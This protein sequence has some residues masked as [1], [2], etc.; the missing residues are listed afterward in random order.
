MTDGRR[1][2]SVAGS[3]DQDPGPGR[4]R[5]LV[6]RLPIAFLLVSTLVLRVPVSLR[7]QEEAALV[8]LTLE[9]AVAEARSGN[10]A[11]RTAEARAAMARA[12]ARAATGRLL[13]RLRGTAGFTRSVDPVFAFGTKL[14]QERF[15]EE[16][17]A[18][19]A[20]N[21]PEPITDWTAEAGVRWRAVD[22]ERW[23]GRTAARRRASA[24]GWQEEW[25]REFTDFRT[26][27]LY[28]GAAGAEAGLGAAETAEGAAR[29]TLE[30]FRRRRQEGLL[31]DA[32]V[33]QAEAELRSAE[34]RLAEAR[35]D[36]DRAREELT[37]HLGWDPDRVPV[38]SDTLAAPP[39]PAPPRGE[40]STRADIRSL[41][42]ARA[43]AGADLRR[44]SLA[45]LPT[46]EGFA[47]WVSHAGDIGV[48]A[49]DWTV[50]VALS[51]TLFS[52]F[53]RIAERQRAARGREI[54][55]IRYREAL[56][57]ARA[58]M[59]RAHREVTAGWSGLQ[60]TRAAA[61]AAEAARFLVRRRFEEGLAT[62]ADLL[63]A[64]ARATAARSR[65]VERLAAYAVS[66]A[67]LE[68]VAQGAVDAGRGSAPAGS[69]D[70]ASAR[71]GPEDTREEAR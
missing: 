69:R 33:L 58:E 52:G 49:S 14:R 29:A 40:A 15:G 54:A 68:L 41:A 55:R 36:A 42:E 9:E 65:A 44:A 27:A 19:E 32:D 56:R 34:A 37:L 35:R 6:S 21:R 16:D 25:S 4:A 26:K 53:E 22:A 10:A 18:L 46:L 48:D 61:E 70:A 2:S 13:P 11:Y 12:D 62:A 3:S 24:V 60:A 43:A 7:A 30:L 38:L 51:W 45:F 57:T 59:A 47:G 17:F 20:L 31:T 66:L 28:Y 39:P 50:G 23:S 8:P 71:V 67:H 5:G 1:D 64:E 63:H